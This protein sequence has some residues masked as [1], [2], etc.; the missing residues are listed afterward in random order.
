MLR[1]SGRLTSKPER[2]LGSIQ[3]LV[4]IKIFLRIYWP[5]LVNQNNISQEYVLVGFF[6]WPHLPTDHDRSPFKI[7]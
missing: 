1:K 5:W 3:N 4:H 7:N 6:R 2:S